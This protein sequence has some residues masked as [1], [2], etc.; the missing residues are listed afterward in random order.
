MKMLK[1]YILIAIIALPTGFLSTE[2]FS[3]ACGITEEVI[4]TLRDY[5]E[6]NY[7]VW[8]FV[9][10]EK[11]MERFMD[12]V[13]MPN[14]NIVAAGYTYPKSRSRSASPLLIEVTR[15]NQIIWAN[16]HVD[17]EESVKLRKIRRREEGG[18][19]AFGEVL[20]KNGVSVWIGY[21][22]D[23]G[24]LEKKLAISDRKYDLKVEDIT[25]PA[26]GDGF[27]MSIKANDKTYQSREHGVIYRVSGKGGVIWK[28]SY[29]PG[30]NNRFS[31]I[32]TVYDEAGIPFYIAAGSFDIG[33]QRRA[34]FILAVDEKG[35]LAWSEQYL[36]GSYSGFRQVAPVTDG[37][38][39]VIGDVEPLEDD[40]YKHSAWIMRVETE[41]GDTQWE[42][43]VAVN[44]YKV[45]GRN[46]MGYKDGRIIAGLETLNSEGGADSPEMVRLLTL[47]SRGVI[48]QDDPYLE[49][50]SVRIRALKLNDKQHRMVVGYAYNSFKADNEDNPY[51]YHTEDGWIILAPSLDPYTDPCIPRRRY[52]E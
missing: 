42:R 13:E 34:G 23:D 35:R 21:Y 27:V 17:L 26:N 51:N 9:Y 5:R 52:N 36:R 48:V 50:S 18:F 25:E 19:V 22:S 4:I 45:Y 43:F 3:Q 10:G 37:D 44:G 46:V 16:R 1:I 14:N 49:G 30:I 2:V 12:A 33:P 31:G 20:G 38:F 15:R 40:E 39:V 41:S 7:S 8:D 29:K 11:H 32:A 47:T 24:K 6:G 28:R